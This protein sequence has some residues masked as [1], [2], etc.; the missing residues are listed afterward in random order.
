MV[1]ISNC[2]KGKEYV[3]LKIAP[4]QDTK[5]VDEHDKPIRDLRLYNRTR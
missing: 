5:F 3:S 2:K 4:I 1:I